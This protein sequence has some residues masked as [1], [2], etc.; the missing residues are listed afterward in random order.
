[1]PPGCTTCCISPIAAT[2]SATKLRTRPE[3]TPP[4]ANPQPRRET[5]EPKPPEPVTE[6]AGRASPALV[7]TTRL[8]ASSAHRPGRSV[9]IRQHQSDAQSSMALLSSG[10]FTS[11]RPD[12]FSLKSRSHPSAFS[13]ASWRL[14]RVGGG[15]TRIAYQHGEIRG[16][17]ASTFLSLYFFDPIGSPIVHS[18]PDRETNMYSQTAARAASMW[19]LRPSL[20]GR[21][22]SCKIMAPGLMSGVAWVWVTT[23]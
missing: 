17:R 20:T 4:Q 5:A 22:S 11:S 1:M 19:P 3:T 14:R 13:M 21:V 16:S 10:R 15:K 18:N 23:S 2:R 12:S 6:Q 9:P 7:G 8:P